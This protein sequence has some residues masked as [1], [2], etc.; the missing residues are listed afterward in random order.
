MPGALLVATVLAMAWAGASATVRTY[1]VGGDCGGLP[2]IKVVMP[3]G[4]YV[5][6]CAQGLRF[7]RGVAV[8]PTGDLVLAVVC[9]RGK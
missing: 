4:W 8:L 3:P 5:G 7:P 1:P 6:L 2:K 9:H